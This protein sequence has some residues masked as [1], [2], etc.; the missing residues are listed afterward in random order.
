MKGR[1]G[2]HSF[3]VLDCVLKVTTNKKYTPEKML[4]TPILGYRQAYDVGYCLADNDKVPQ[5]YTADFCKIH[6]ELFS[7]HNFSATTS[8][9]VTVLPRNSRKFATAEGKLIP[10][11]VEVLTACTCRNV[12][13]QSILAV[14]RSEKKFKYH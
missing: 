14:T 8:K 4:D 10:L 1:S 7:K 13:F 9:S 5:I 12:D 3:I 6:N 11:N 2:V